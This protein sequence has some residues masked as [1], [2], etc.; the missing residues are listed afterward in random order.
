MSDG[1][2]DWQ[3]SSQ[4][5]HEYKTSSKHYRR[6]CL[7]Y[8]GGSLMA[9]G[10]ISRASAD[11]SGPEKP[12]DEG[13]EPYPQTGSI[14]G[15]LS[16]DVY[17]IAP[18]EFPLLV[19]KVE[20]YNEEKDTDNI[21]HPALKRQLENHDS[22]EI[23]LTICTIGE[24]IETTSNGTP[25]RDLFGFRCTSEEV[26]ELAKYGDVVSNPQVT[27]TELSLH[28]VNVDKLEEI[29][30]LPFV[31]EINYE[32]KITFDLEE[33]G[34]PEKSFVDLDSLRGPDYHGYSEID[35]DW[36]VAENLKIGYID[37]GYKGDG[38]GPFSESYAEKYGFVNGSEADKFHTGW[39]D[40]DS[41]GDNPK[42][43]HGDATMDLAAYMLGEQNVPDSV[44]PPMVPF[45]VYGDEVSVI[46]EAINHAI[47]NN[48][49]VLSAS[50]Q[51]EDWN[52]TCPSIFCSNLFA[53]F[54]F[55]GLFITST[56][57]EGHAYQVDY[58][59]GGYLSIGVGAADDEEIKYGYDYE[60]DPDSN[61][62]KIRFHECSQCFQVFDDAKFSPNVY[63]YGAVEGDDYDYEETSAATAQVSISALIMKSV[64]DLK[65]KDVVAIFDS[66]DRHKIYP[67]GAASAGQ[68]NDAEHAYKKSPHRGRILG[69]ANDEDGITIRDSVLIKQELV[70]MEPEDIINRKGLA[71]VS[72]TGEIGVRDSVLIQQH[73]VGMDVENNLKLNSIDVDDPYPIRGARIEISAELTNDNDDN[74]FGAV[75]PITLKY[76]RDTTLF[77]THS[78][79]WI[80]LEGG[81]SQTYQFPV[82]IPR[83]VSPGEELTF[84]VVADDDTK[85]TSVTISSTS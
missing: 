8:L 44:E 53:Y 19:S 61:Y 75:G 16:S 73:L 26:S 71:D 64:G 70:G 3:E 78:I 84:T 60:R 25:Q 80:D 81:E 21:L 2:S 49:P 41:W 45:Y 6:D 40:P 42:F 34:N 18:T 68:F 28:N 39:D 4:K 33:T 79:K 52:S 57:N 51:T 14:P 36:E 55:G 29:A 85:S 76:D 22:K 50:W 54:L 83:D 32:P 12:I 46:K 30:N 31:L 65:Y 77:K 58:P 67:D 27:T 24:R 38:H 43:Y 62:G 69:D 66:M 37:N 1:N 20:Q 23:N 47:F 48:I 72:Q 9:L 10:G 15:D 35:G 63:G 17:F 13:P 74:D 59:G 5:E 11:N 82:D 56:G 7:Q